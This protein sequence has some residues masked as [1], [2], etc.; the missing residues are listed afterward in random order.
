MTGHEFDRPKFRSKAAEQ[1]YCSMKN[2]MYVDDCGTD[3]K[4]K[5]FFSLLNGCVERYTRREFVRMAN[6]QDALTKRK[7]VDTIPVKKWKEMTS[8]NDHI[9]LRVEIANHFS[10]CD[11]CRNRYKEFSDAFSF[12]AQLNDDQ[13]RLQRDAGVDFRG[14]LAAECLLTDS[15]THTIK[16]DFGDLAY[17]KVCNCLR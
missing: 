3:D 11:G 15:M 4:G 13:E 5:I 14:W 8:G 9:G 12:L 7:A 1:L 16:L 10:G 6:A 17:Q 2:R